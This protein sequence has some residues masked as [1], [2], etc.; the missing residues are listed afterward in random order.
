MTSPPQDTNPRLAHSF[1]GVLAIALGAFA[2]VVQ[3]FLPVGLLPDISRDLGVSEGT[4]GLAVTATAVLGAVAAPITTV[5]IRGLDRRLALLG[6]TMLLLVSAILSATAEGFLVLVIARVILGIG[7]GGF[8]A[9]SLTAASRLVPPEKVAKASATVLGGISI[10]SVVSVPF[11]AYVGAHMDWHIA[12]VA[13]GVLGA[14]VAGLQAVMLPK[15]PAEQRVAA[16]SYTGL[17]RLSRV[18]IILTT[19]ILLVAGHY[20]AYTYINPL[21]Q[22]VTGFGPGVVS[23]LLLVYGVVTFLGNFVGGFLAARGVFRAVALTASLFVVSLLV[24]AVLGTVGPV[25][26]AALVVW[27]LAWGMAPV[28]VQLWLFHSA[29]QAPE[30]AQ[31]MLSSVIQLAIGLGSLLGAV[32]MNMGGV[33]GAAW[34]AIAVLAVAGVVVAAVSRRIADPA[35]R[36]L[37]ETDMQPFASGGGV[38]ADKLATTAPAECRSDATL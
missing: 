33:R 34:T 23:A 14:A 38:T 36:P 5:L 32:T 10:A 9:I 12:F 16:S 24:M 4:A 17:L 11:G 37:A 15:I 18:R 8:W 28:T 35:P 22:N 27:A 6:L 30:A 7:V 29:R 13:S 26:I 20:V 31:A 3:E 2:L 1:K 25:A 21:L 19:V